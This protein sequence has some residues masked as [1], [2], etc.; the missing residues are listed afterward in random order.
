MSR[1]SVE[2]VWRRLQEFYGRAKKF[3]DLDLYEIESK[4]FL[5][6]HSFGRN[7]FSVFYLNENMYWQKEIEEILRYKG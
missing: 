6:R 4:N 1:E 5:L 3:G 2:E 7:Y